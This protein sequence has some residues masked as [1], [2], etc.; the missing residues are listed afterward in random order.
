MKKIEDYGDMWHFV[1]DT[2]IDVKNGKFDEI[3]AAQK[4]MERFAE[5]LEN[6]GMSIDQIPTIKELKI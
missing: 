3:D 2:V 4:V 5:L 6:N 1:M